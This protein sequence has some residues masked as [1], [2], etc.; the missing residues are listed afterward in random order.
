MKYINIKTNLV[1]SIEDIRIL[2]PRVSI[3]EGADLS[4]IGYLTVEKTVPPIIEQDKIAKESFPQEYT[5]GKWKEVWIIEDLPLQNTLTPKQLRIALRRLGLRAKV[6]EVVSNQGGDIS[7]YWFFS[8]M[9]NREDP[10][11]N[12]LLTQEEINTVWKLGSTL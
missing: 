6:E 4:D 10:L 12:E 3:P 11:M 1:V 2:N 9:F 5:A 7:D 8:F